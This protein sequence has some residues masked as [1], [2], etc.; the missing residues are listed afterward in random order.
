MAQSKKSYDNCKHFVL[1]QGNKKSHNI[2]HI[3]LKAPGKGL[4]TFFLPTTN[5]PFISLLSSTICFVTTSGWL[6]GTLSEAHHL[7]F[8]SHTDQCL[9]NAFAEYIYVYMLMHKAKNNLILV[10]F[11]LNPYWIDSHDAFRTRNSA[12]SSQKDKIPNAYSGLFFT[13]L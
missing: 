12:T 5:G 4:S 7:S 13:Q 2:T 9:L 10:D 11:L 3:I 1:K 8:F 6:R